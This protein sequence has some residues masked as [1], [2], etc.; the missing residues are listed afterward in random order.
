MMTCEHY[1][2][3]GVLLA[4]R[5]EDDP[6]RETCVVCKGEHEMRRAI[7]EALP[8]VDAGEIGDPNWQ[9]RVWKAIGEGRAVKQRPVGVRWFVGSALATA[10]SLVLVS[11][12]VIIR[13]PVLQIAKVE[14]I[15]RHVERGASAMK[16]SVG[17]QVRA[18]VAKGADV[19]VYRDHDLVRWCGPKVMNDGCSIEGDTLIVA[20]EA[21]V[22]GTYSVII[23]GPR[24]DDD[25]LP[26]L[27]VPG[28]NMKD[29]LEALNKA[30]DEIQIHEVEIR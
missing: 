17:D 12:L 11:W 9:Q 20:V 29:D 27:P 16:G 21:K 7:I 1:E 3:V 14:V 5:G 8:L 10:C 25:K 19:R 26:R 6:H 18:T 28:A 4:E 2:R 23:V 24:S 13:E 30:G 15:T 22:A